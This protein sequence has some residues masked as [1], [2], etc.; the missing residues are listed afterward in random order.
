MGDGS[1]LAGTEWSIHSELTGCKNIFNQ[2]R[3][4][5]QEKLA[6]ISAGSPLWA[7]AEDEIFGSGE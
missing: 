4:R 6:S 5:A 3:E 7:L 1:K 2:I